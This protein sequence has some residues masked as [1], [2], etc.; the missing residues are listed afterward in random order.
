[1]VK[2]LMILLIIFLFSNRLSLNSFPF[3][4]NLAFN[5]RSGQREACHSGFE[6]IFTC[7]TEPTGCYLLRGRRNLSDFL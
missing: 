5:K 3:N 6:S 7:V 2:T 1:M 4:I